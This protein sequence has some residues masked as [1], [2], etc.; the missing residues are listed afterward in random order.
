MTDL[1]NQDSYHLKIVKAI[2][3]GQSAMCISSFPTS[4]T[5]IQDLIL[6]VIPAPE[7][8]AP[9]IIV[10]CA[11]NLFAQEL[12]NQLAPFIKVRDLTLDLLLE[13]GNKVK[14]RN[15]LYDGTEIIIGTSRRVCEMY[16][17]NGFNISKLK[18]FIV[19]QMD[20]QVKYGWR[21]FIGRIAESLPKCKQLLFM[22]NSNDE[23]IENYVAEFMPIYQRIAID[24]PING[25]IINE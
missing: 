11:D 13:K 8:G 9:R 2:K 10:V 16:F 24:L 4:F 12:A 14:Q 22:E 21:G 20:V 1:E 6:Q 23:R 17:Q 18:L 3:A 25:Q 15:D 7:E 19:L 5:L